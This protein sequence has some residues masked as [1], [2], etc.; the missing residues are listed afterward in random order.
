VTDTT[1]VVDASDCVVL[2][3]AGMCMHRCAG[4]SCV[5][6]SSVGILLDVTLTSIH[7]K[8]L[9]LLPASNMCSVLLL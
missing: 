3:G 9:V 2:G 8:H 1:T 6:F 4:F 7:Q 5:A